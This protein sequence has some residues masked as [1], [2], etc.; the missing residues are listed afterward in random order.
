MATLLPRCSGLFR[1]HGLEMEKKYPSLVL[2][3]DGIARHE[4]PGDV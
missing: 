2:L 4:I 3:G 1:E